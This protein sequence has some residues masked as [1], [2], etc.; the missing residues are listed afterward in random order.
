MTDKRIDPDPISIFLGVMGALGS[1]L[2]VAVAVDSRSK[3]KKNEIV[4]I[5]E[6][7]R[8]KVEEI[9]RTLRDID[10]SFEDLLSL[11]QKVED[12]SGNNYFASRFQAGAF[13]LLLPDEM[14][15]YVQ[16]K[17][18]LDQSIC[19]ITSNLNFVLGQVVNHNPKAANVFIEFSDDIQR[20]LNLILLEGASY[21]AASENIKST[22]DL[23]SRHLR[24]ARG[25]R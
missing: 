25:N 7:V 20:C 21:T 14:R 23:V 22:I 1:F 12:D 2:G 19:K 8:N 5:E 9:R 4:Q 3:D 11:M 10:D 17:S 24:D 18:S 15:Q 16:I 13:L 6:N